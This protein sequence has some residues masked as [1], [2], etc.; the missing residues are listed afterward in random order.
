MKRQI[1][2]TIQGTRGQNSHGLL[3]ILA[4]ASVLPQRSLGQD[5]DPKTEPEVAWQEPH[6][7]ELANVLK[8]YYTV[9][10]HSDMTSICR[11]DRR[12][13]CMNGD[14]EDQ[15]WHSSTPREPERIERFVRRMTE[16]ALSRPDD[17]LGFAQAVYAV[18]RLRPPEDA[19]ALAADCNFVDWWCALI[20]GMVHQR[21]GRP[22]RAERYFRAALPEADSALAC[23]LTGI[24]E[25]LD[26]PDSR[27]Y[28]DLSCSER[29]GFER[30]F[31]W[32]T[33]P[34][35]SRPGND[36]WAEHIARR[37]ELILHERLLG[38]TGGSHPASH[39]ESVVRRGHEDSWRTVPARGSLQGLQEMTG[40]RRWTSV[41]AAR[42][43]FTPVSAI[44]DGLAALQYDL[45]ADRDDEGYTPAP[46]GPVFGLPAQFA[47]FREGE[48]LFV[49]AAAELDGLP[50]PFANTLF[51]LS[52]GPDSIPLQLGRAARTRRPVFDALL[53]PAPALLAIESAGRS[54]AV[55]RARG[56]GGALG[57][58]GFA[59]SDALL[60][61]PD[62]LDLPASRDE[63]VASMLGSTTIGGTEMVVYWEIYGVAKDRPLA[64]SLSI[65][66]GPAGWFTRVLR[67]LRVRSEEQGP[68]VSW[69]ESSTGP[70]HLV[71]ISLDI[72]G[73]ED[74][75]YQLGITV[76]D[77]GGAEAANTRRFRVDRN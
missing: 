56:G 39:E 3:V 12:E 26:G 69:T 31:W 68:V 33:D 51:V 62:S 19:L 36:R 74:G 17:A 48:W 13:V 76:A 9:M 42:Y 16:V 60:V 14:H 44:G 61:T 58:G 21:A 66:D 8:A 32:F 7:G 46:Y 15:R 57:G 29:A 28:R 53:D 47:R 64:I 77:E 30:R 1:F 50:L 10:I 59:L 45:A 71:A 4:L 18:A 25:L 75:T 5:A 24:D 41:R 38:A 2:R 35:I 27:A 20:V 37:F 22:E 65:D 43:R 34:L 11:A 6:K 73:L 63:A 52:A 70:T 67:A 72:G 54:E 49:A 23:R 40:F 55:G